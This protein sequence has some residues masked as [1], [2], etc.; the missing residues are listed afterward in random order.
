MIYD[1]ITD[2]NG[3]Q[4]DLNDPETYEKSWFPDEFIDADAATLREE[5]AN[6][7]GQSLYHMIC[8]LPDTDWDERNGVH[9]G[10]YSRVVEFG[11]HFA[12]ES[13]EPDR[14]ENIAWLKKQLFKIR[15][16]TG[17]QC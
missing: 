8:W 5:I 3:E 9:P 1:Y 13:R 6:Q 14:Y 17:N 2:S 12:K 4:W 10:Q 7:I 11:K 16:E 15:D